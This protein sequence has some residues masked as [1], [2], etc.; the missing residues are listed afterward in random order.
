MIIIVSII[1]YI[2]GLPHLLM[3]LVQLKQKTVPVKNS[4]LFILGSISILLTSLFLENTLVWV[5][6]MTIG[7]V[8]I[9]ISAMMNGFYLHGKITLSHQ[10]VRFILF[11]IILITY[12]LSI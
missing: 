2:Y 7:F 8:L 12:L 10:L 11:L 5:I 4:I 1:S 6:L 9:Q 3:G